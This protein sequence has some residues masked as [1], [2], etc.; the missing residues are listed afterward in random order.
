[1]SPSRLARAYRREAQTAARVMPWLDGLT[2]EQ[3]A[4]FRQHGRLLAELLVAQLDAADDES[5]LSS[6]NSAAQEA[7]A[8]GRVAAGLKLSLGQTVEGFLQFRRPFLHQLGLFAS[9]RAL[10]ATATAALMDQ[11]ERSMD[12]LLIAAMAGHGVER[13]AARRARQDRGHAES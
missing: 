10:D 4:W 8:Y 1:M 9:R 5:A 12:R 3:R 11:A 2:E 13:V 7:A 6:M